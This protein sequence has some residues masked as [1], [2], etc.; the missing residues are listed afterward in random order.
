[1]VDINFGRP[2][3]RPIQFHPLNEEDEAAQ[4]R[5]AGWDPRRTYEENMGQ[6]SVLD[7]SEEFDPMG[8]YENDGL[9]PD[10]A[11]GMSSGGNSAGR[12]LQ[13]RESNSDLRMT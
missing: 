9:P 1:M 10:M 4:Y 11:V 13:F 8:R 2:P 3:Y 6:A 7:P 12:P 5:R